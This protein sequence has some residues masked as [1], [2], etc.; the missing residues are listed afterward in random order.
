M[1]LLNLLTKR[2]ISSSDSSSLHSSSFSLLELCALK[3]T[4]FFFSSFVAPS[5]YLVT[6]WTCYWWALL[7]KFV[8]EW[9]S[10]NL[11]SQVN[12]HPR[13]FWEAS[14]KFVREIHIWHL[15]SKTF[16]IIHNV[17]QPVKHLG[18]TFHRRAHLERAG[19][20]KA[21]W[22]PRTTKS[23]LDKRRHWCRIKDTD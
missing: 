4:L 15:K 13:S 18:H 3:A 8:W 16:Q 11:I 10:S 7:P 20:D 9:W 1:N 6:S 2:I 5:T 22:R 21:G 19:R 17:I 23:S 14:K 12:S